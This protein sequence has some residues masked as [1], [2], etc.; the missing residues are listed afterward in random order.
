MSSK[1]TFQ[2]QYGLKSQCPPNKRGR[3]MGEILKQEWI[4]CK[5]QLTDKSNEPNLIKAALNNIQ[6]YSA[7][8]VWR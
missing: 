7:K 8:S 4:Y 1:Y 6:I 5:S 3:K 2:S